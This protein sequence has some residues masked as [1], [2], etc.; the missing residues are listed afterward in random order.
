MQELAGTKEFVSN[1]LDK[2][3]IHVNQALE[4]GN[5]YED[6]EDSQQDLVDQRVIAS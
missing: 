2:K 1:F 6:L 4:K 5:D 3:K